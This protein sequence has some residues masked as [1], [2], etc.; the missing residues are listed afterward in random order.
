M[1]AA[2]I[3]HGNPMNALDR[4][5]Y[6][7][8]WRALGAVI[9]KPRAVVVISAH[10]YINATAV[11]AM[12]RPRTIHD[13][14][15][16]PPELYEV[17]YSAPGYP[18]LVGEISELVHPTWIGADG[19]SWGLDHGAWSVLTHM[20]PDADVPVVQLAINATKPL[21]YHFEL[22]EQLAPLRDREILLIGSGNIVHNLGIVDFGAGESGEQWAHR[23]DDAARAALTV[24][25]HVV[26]DLEHHRDFDLAVP[27]AD[28]FIPMLYIAGVAAASSEPAEV[29]VDGYFGGSLSMTSY[30]VGAPVLGP[31]ADPAGAPPLPPVPADETNL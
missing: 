27:T 17:R 26:L 20:F 6:T 13:F 4:N 14:Y 19:D 25:P 12:S 11:T 23:F 31:V 9:P 18:D 2:F 30:T 28:H 10:W 29:L 21:H 22:G 8:T 5:R 15:G 7:E 3:G 24:D 1:P 16:F